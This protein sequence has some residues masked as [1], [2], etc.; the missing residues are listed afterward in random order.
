[1]TGED[2]FSTLQAVSS[3]AARDPEKIKNAR[4][5]KES[6]MAPDFL[7]GLPYRSKVM[8]LSKEVWNAWT[9]NQQAEFIKEV[10]AKINYYET[11]HN[12]AEQWKPLEESASPGDYV[13]AIPL[14]QLL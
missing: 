9:Q 1:M 3:A 14:T 12:D 11:I 4:N 6:G 2:F 7:L 8:E 10:R 5:I 13:A